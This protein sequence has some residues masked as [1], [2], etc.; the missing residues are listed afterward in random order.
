MGVTIKRLCTI[1]AR[2]GSKGVPG[3]NIRALLGK[4]L[5]GHSIDQAR[6]SGLFDHIAV[7]SNSDEILAVAKEYGADVLIRRPDEMASDQAAKL[8]A[9]QHCA[10]EAEA[11]T[12][13]AYDTFCDL[14]ATSPL[15]STDDITG[16]VA[17]MERGG[18]DNVI[19][20]APAHRSPYFNLVERTSDD[21]VR[22]CKKPKDELVRRQDAPE[23]YDCNA[24]IYVWSRE[25]M[26]TLDSVLSEKTAIFAMP[27]ERSRDIDSELD[28]ELVEFLMQR[29]EE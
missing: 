8:P 28:F 21:F 12:G 18:C 4:P 29:K 23:C 25:S 16:A 10:R 2:G 20:G 19:T 26:F 5:I 1:C 13:L 27:E 3:K 15:R 11:H 14:D 17:R 22:L 7:S 24:S 6:Q 9:I